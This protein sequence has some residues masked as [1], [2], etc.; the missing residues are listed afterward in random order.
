MRGFDLVQRYEASLADEGDLPP[1]SPDADGYV[2]Q[3]ADT[4]NAEALALETGLSLTRT[5]LALAG[6]MTAGFALSPPVL[7]GPGYFIPPAGTS[8]WEAVQRWQATS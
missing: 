4:W 2:V 8:V 5:Q 7:N 3:E 1:R 6:L